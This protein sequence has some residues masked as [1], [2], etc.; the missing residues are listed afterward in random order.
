VL[1]AVD[2]RTDD[3]HFPGIGRYTRN[4]AHALLRT[5]TAADEIVLITGHRRPARGPVRVATV[6]ASP[7]SL[8]QHWAIPA[9]LHRLGAHLYH[10]P[11]FLMPFRPRIPCVVTI[12]DLIPLRFPHYF[13][14]AQRLLYRLALRRAVQVARILIAVS[15]ATRSDLVSLL[16]VD[17]HRI[18][19]VHEGV[20]PLFT[21]AAPPAIAAMRNRIGLP[22]R[23]A[24]CVGSN[25][26]HKNL[27]RLVD[28]WA[29]LRGAIPLIVA[30]PWDARFPEARRR[31]AALEAAGRLRWIGHVADSDLP[32][33]YTGAQCLVAPSECEGFGLPVLEAMA[34]G[35][36]VACAQAGSLPE[37]AGDAAVL[38]DPGD[39]DSIAHALDGLL[40]DDAQRAALMQRGLARAATFT[41]DAAATQTWEVYRRAVDEGG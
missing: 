7:F 1:V 34:C 11:Y 27:V 23:Y 8:R 2:T 37:V 13:T 29:Q 41:W 10:S 15:D 18:R 35:T 20:E 3:P 17:P 28:A 16:G 31:G 39:V 40:A 38:F 6:A 36:P 14:A 25:K 24:L 21:P 4:L 30:G 22:D 5:A 9:H 12:H 33:L 32:A 26:P 19:V